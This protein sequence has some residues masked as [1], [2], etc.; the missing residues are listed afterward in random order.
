MKISIIGAGPAGAIAAYYSS[1][2]GHEVRIYERNK[3]FCK[4]PC[5]DGLV[6]RG[7]DVVPNEVHKDFILK[8]FTRTK[9]YWYFDLLR[10]IVDEKMP[11]HTIDKAKMV[12]NILDASNIKV[13][14]GMKINE[15]L[16]DTLKQTSDLVVIA[17]GGSNSLAKNHL[18]YIPHQIP[19]LRRYATTKEL[20]DSYL[21]MFMIPQ[22]Y[23]WAF[24]IGDHLFNIG[25]GQMIGIKE[26][27]NQELLE[28]FIAQF[29]FVPTTRTEGNPI[30]IDI[31]A[32]KLREGK[33]V[34]IGECVG[35]VMSGVGEG[36]SWSMVAGSICFKPNYEQ[37]YEP[38]RQ[39][40]IS[41][42]N[43]L[44]ELL[45]LENSEKRELLATAPDE[46]LSHYLTG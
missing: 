29:H 40:L 24:P 43:L 11:I 4:K 26:E 14:L 19:V 37:E 15:S 39:Q 45:K 2:A 23:I 3:V 20:D 9:M 22:G 36:D 12:S 35:Q 18:G 33:I 30:V 16:L 42:K 5:G 6:Q 1:K 28:R 17:D 25:V 32:Q 21:H 31:P 34:G 38:Y 46:F 27:S 13:E 10:E 44:D 8:S 7:L 41:G